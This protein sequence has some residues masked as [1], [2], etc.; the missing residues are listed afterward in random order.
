MGK[1]GSGSQHTPV[2]APNTLQS[3][4]IARVVDLISEGEIVG[5]INGL[6][7]VY[8]DD[9]PLQNANGTFNYKN[10]ALDS[11][12][13]LPDQL[14]VLGFSNI[15]TEVAVSTQVTILTGPLTRTVTSTT[16][17]SLRITVQVPALSASDQQSGDINPTSVALKIEVQPNGGAFTTVVNDTIDGKTTSPYQRAYKFALPGS[18]PWNIRVTRI[19][20]DSTS[21]LLQ[22]QLFWASYTIIEDWQLKYIDSAIIATAVD[23]K[24]FGGKVPVRT[25]LVK[26]IKVSV[27][28]NYDPIARTYATTGT[29]TTSGAWDGTFKTAWTDNPAWIF[30]DVITNDR[31]GLGQ[32]VPTGSVDKFGLYTISQY[33]D[34]LV[35]DGLGGFEPRY[36]L[37]G[38]IATADDALKVLIMIAAVFR[39][40]VYWGPNGVA[41]VADMPGNPGKLITP[42]N[43]IDGTINYQ[44]SALKARHSAVQVTWYNPANLYQPEIELVEDAASI[45]RFGYRLL[46]FVAFGC[47]SRGRA[48]RYGRWLLDTERHETETATWVASW[49]QSDVMPGDIVEIA[50]PAYSGLDFGGRLVSATSTTLTVDRP[51]VIESGKS[52]SID[53]VVV[54]GTIAHRG[55]T[56][57]PGTV[58]VLT[59]DSALTILPVVNAIWVLTSS[60]VSPRQFRVITRI[61]SDKHL[62]SITALLHDAT[63]YDR[64]ELGLKIE[65]PL[66]TALP[67]GPLLAPT[68]LTISECIAI[69]AAGVPDA[70][71][72]MSWSAPKDARVIS[73]EVQTL[74]PGQNWQ[75]FD[76]ISAVSVDFFGLKAGNWGFRVRS[77][78]TLDVVSPWLTV[79]ATVVA[80][81]LLPPNDLT[82]VRAAYV[83]GVMN[84]R[85]DEIVDFRPVKY[86]VR[87]GD[88]WIASVNI[89]TVL[90][91][92]FETHGDG[93]YWISAYIGPDAG[94]RT[95]ALNPSEISVLGS[96]ITG[97]VLAS[98]DEAATGWIG[99]FSG[100][101]GLDSSINAARTSG[102]NNEL[103]DANILLNLDILNAGGDGSG[104]YEIPAAHY[105]DIGRVAPCPV[106]IAW[107]ATGNPAVQNILTEVNILVDLDFLGA[108]RT[109]FIDVHPEIAVAQTPGVW[110]PYQKFA[111]GTYVGRVFKSRIFLGTSDPTTVAYA[112]SYVFTV[113]VPDRTDHKT[114][115]VVPS[116]GLPII[117]TP[118]GTPM[119]SGS[120]Y[121]FLGGSALGWTGASLTLT[122]GAGL[123]ITPTGADPMLISPTL[124]VNGAVYRYI[125]IDIDRLSLLTIGVPQFN[126]FYAT[127][128]HAESASFFKQFTPLVNTIGAH[129]FYILDMGVLTLGGNDWITSTIDHFRID[130]D[131]GQSGPVTP[132][133]TYRINSIMLLNSIPAPFNGGPNNATVP[134]VQVTIHDAQSGDT[135]TITGRTK[136]GCTLNITNAA[137]PVQRNNVDITVQGF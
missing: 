25:F 50:D 28:A 79:E 86:E 102:I 133:A 70:K 44:G 49:D 60:A 35:P 117:F 93:N 67:T 129:A 106:S 42:A 89:G 32:F 27:P 23:A 17:T 26:G 131:D 82:N 43:V 52:Y 9:T 54:D 94:P 59:L 46:S 95:Y 132:N 13:G 122:T 14:P 16:A 1:G 47:T 80:G 7:S 66:F 61:E 112:L 64:I 6:Q 4:S 81:L 12:P 31:Y 136:S 73:Y 41:A 84:I 56:T 53:I 115:V 72:V 137:T 19:T 134:N 58:T 78:S 74:P 65:P 87:K 97:N 101:A 34:A 109:Q 110:G 99:I 128:G 57:A 85:W 90:H 18:S 125:V 113:D 76:I 21:A 36:T 51:I 11:R 37:N 130:F 10:V 92:P 104:Y 83:D 20:A 39:G 68:A 22:N 120:I 108:S 48:N 107:K 98:W 29:G 88:S 96:Q 124:G 105:V 121:S 40:M 45:A 135:L 71:I 2:E 5:L 30:Y 114:S 33:C 69:G 3:N 15:E 111:P 103:V 126:I 38:V 100:A 75:E 8:F 24:S 77:V 55:I 127:G 119:P 123:V 63:K 116:T 62:F 91:P 118:D